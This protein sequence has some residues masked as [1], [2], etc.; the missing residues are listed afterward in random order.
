MILILN[1]QKISPVPEV[2]GEYK[3]Y[4]LHGTEVL[5]F[6]GTAG[7]LFLQQVNL[8]HAKLSYLLVAM[9][10]QA[11]VELIARKAGVCLVLSIR[12]D[13]FCNSG[14]Q[15]QTLLKE[16][17]CNL[18]CQRG[19]R[20][21]CI[22]PANTLY[23]L[24]MVEYTTEILLHTLQTF[25]TLENRVTQLRNQQYFSLF[26]ESPFAGA[27][28]MEAAVQCVQTSYYP[29]PRHFHMELMNRLL[30]GIC[31]QACGDPQHTVRF[32]LEE[33]DAL[34]AARILIDQNL[35]RHFSVEEIARHCG[36]NR[37]KLRLGF[38]ALFGKGIYT[39]LL[40]RRLELAKGLLEG[41]RKPIKEI[42]K[43][44]GYRNASNFNAACKKYFGLT[45][46]QIRKGNSGNG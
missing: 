38:T 25:T 12:G 6:T 19:M 29:Q 40:H 5:S 28:I 17:Q 16:T 33:A 24:L 44:A 32:R 2:P 10:E 26:P 36:L 35:N 11:E 1:H 15:E 20:T 14:K 3:N 22:P 46:L 13:W 43:T 31:A 27:V 23:G 30:H 42:A 34:H 9:K 7:I 39:Y 4:H 45:P 41:S 37:E 18:F 8:G 21:C